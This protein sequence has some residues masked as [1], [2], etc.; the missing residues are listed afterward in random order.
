MDGRGCWHEGSF[1]VRR[2][3]PRVRFA[4]P[5][6]FLIHC[7]V[8]SG[9]HAAPRVH[10]NPRAVQEFDDDDDD[11]G[12]VGFDDEAFTTD[13][14]IEVTHMKKRWAAKEEALREGVCIA[15]PHPRPLT[16]TTH[17]AHTSAAALC[18]CDR[19]VAHDQVSMR[20]GYFTSQRNWYPSATATHRCRDQTGEESRIVK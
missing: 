15:R 9:A 10:A 19:P 16:H 20:V 4:L 8:V 18:P 17:R 5:G 2:Y 12:G 6:P 3:H 11:D 7:G 14:E 13:W 1:G